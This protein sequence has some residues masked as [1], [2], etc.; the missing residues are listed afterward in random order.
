MS[1]KVQMRMEMDT[2]NLVASSAG[3]PQSRSRSKPSAA[4]KLQCIG[5]IDLVSRREQATRNRGEGSVNPIAT[6]SSQDRQDLV[7]LG[8]SFRPTW[9]IAFAACR[10]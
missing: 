2:E 3:L 4:S 1:T 10:A 6:V 9:A 8:C 7:V 5:A